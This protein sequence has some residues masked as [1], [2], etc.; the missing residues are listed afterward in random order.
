MTSIITEKTAFTEKIDEPVAPEPFDK[1]GPA[2]GKVMDLSETQTF[3]TKRQVVYKR[4]T[5]C[6][7]ECTTCILS[8]ANPV[9]VCND[10]GDRIG[11]ATISADNDNEI[12]AELFIQRDCPERLDIELGRAFP[13]VAWCRVKYKGEDGDGRCDDGQGAHCFYC[14][15]EKT[16]HHIMIASWHDEEI[17]A[18]EPME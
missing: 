14:P 11:F 8:Y 16:I 15:T 1:L 5:Q 7:E 6:C 2:V 4:D 10:E 18:L 13:Q 17:P 9:D 3:K 12:M